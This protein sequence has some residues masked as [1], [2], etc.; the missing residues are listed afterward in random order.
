[1]ESAPKIGKLVAFFWE[2]A[3]NASKLKRLYGKD[4]IT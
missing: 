1:L 3:A 4:T 2:N